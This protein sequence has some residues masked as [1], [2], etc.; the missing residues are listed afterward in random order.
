MPHRAIASALLEI[1]AVVFRPNQPFTFKSG[2]VAPVY[3][4]NRKLPYHPAAW[5]L[6][7]EGLRALVAQH[8][9]PVQVIAGV[10]AAGIPHS[11]ALGYRMG[12]PSIFVRKAAKAHGRQQAIEGGP[13][14][15]KRTLLVEDM[16]TTGGSSL[17]AIQVLREA[18][19]IADVCLCI[20]T[21]G[22]ASTRQRFVESG[23]ML[24]PL[25]KFNVILEVAREQGHFAAEAQTIVEDW[26]SD[27]AGWAQRHGFA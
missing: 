24:N 18:G 3:V 15:G 8:K 16:V 25:V 23:V 13:V 19:A 22:F 12:L 6:V 9:L 14:T 20:T 1:E 7:I 21:Y 2:L 10:E 17:A 26:L 27:P 5:H 4:D 11:A